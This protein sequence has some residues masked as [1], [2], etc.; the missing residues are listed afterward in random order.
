MSSSRFKKSP[1]SKRALNSTFPDRR[2]LLYLITDRNQTAGSSL[3]D[4]IRWSLKSG[5]DCIQIREKDLSD[6]DLFDLACRVV[7][8]ASAT[9]CKVL[10]NGRADIALAAGAH[11]VHLPARGLQACDLR[12]WLPRDFLVGVSVHSLDEA[13]LAALRGADY[14]LLG[15]VFPTPSK[16]KYGAP[17]GLA[18]LKR[19]C[20][21]VPIPVL[22]LGGMRLEKVT[23]VIE[24]GAAG[25]AG[26]SMFQNLPPSPEG[27]KVD[28]LGRKPQDR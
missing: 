28:S 20:R 11:G 9:P 15:P 25:V 8:L 18:Y 10:V 7:A 6:R 17:L 14:L 22:A 1:G 2:P 5:V 21:A 12:A 13:R 16:M 27:A 24:A 3:L 4:V 23:A 26:I 19:V